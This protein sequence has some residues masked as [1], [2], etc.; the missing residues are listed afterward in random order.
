MLEIDNP[1]TWLEGVIA[2]MFTWAIWGSKRAIDSFDRT[3]SDHADRL[4]RLETTVA[5]KN[6]VVAVV[7]RMNEISDQS[8]DQH[9]QILSLLVNRGHSNGA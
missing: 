3:Q 5:T 6:D 1:K 8:R 4:N 2:A 7:D 9:A